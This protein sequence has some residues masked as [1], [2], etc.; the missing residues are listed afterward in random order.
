MSWGP[1]QQSP[2]QDPDLAEHKQL[3]TVSSYAPEHD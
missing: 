1:F 2:L 3:W